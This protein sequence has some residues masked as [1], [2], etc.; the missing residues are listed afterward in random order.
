MLQAAGTVGLREICRYQKSTELLIR[1][2]SF[3]QL[4]REIVSVIT[5]E[6]TYLTFSHCTIS[7]NNMT[8]I[9]VLDGGT[10]EFQATNKI[11]NNRAREGAGIKL[12][13]NAQ[14][15]INTWFSLDM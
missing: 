11:Q 13:P 5:V 14:L 3:Q 7:N 15:Y 6:N 1:K 12:L 2:L 9:T 4:V 8:S 10:V